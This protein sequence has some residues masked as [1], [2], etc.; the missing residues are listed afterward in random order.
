VSDLSVEQLV[1]L[2]GPK[3]Q[4][5][6]E[7]DLP[8]DE[9]Q[10]ISRLRR[11]LSVSEA[12][13]VLRLRRIR[14]RSS[15]R[16]GP[17]APNLLASEKLAEQ[18]SSWAIA[19]YK[20]ELLAKIA[21]GQVWDLCCGAGVDSIALAQ[22]GL[23]VRGVDRSP[24]ARVCLEHNVARMR[25]SKRVEFL[26]SDVEALSLEPQA[27]VHVDPD[28]RAQRGRTADPRFYAPDLKYLAR[29]VASV[30]AGLI[31]LSPAASGES[32]SALADVSLRWVSEAGVCKQLLAGWGQLAGGPSLAAVIVEESSQGIVFHELPA[33]LAGAAGIRQEGRYVFEPD[34]AVVAAGALNDLAARHDLHLRHPALDLLFGDRQIATPWTRCYR[35]LEE[36]PA[37]IGDV[38]KALSRLGGGVVEV[39]PR[40]VKL[41]TDAFQARLRGSGSRMLSLF[42][43]R[44][45]KPVRALICRRL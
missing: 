41:D 6:L 38:R 33:G 24:E 14:T 37:R 27:V 36:L 21:A 29:L 32:L 19:R 9:L 16:L 44:L 45:G 2:A 43:I 42:W 35:I 4:R 20:A 3:G 5:A 28:R 12:S 1:F 22:A 11:H 10:A 26:A 40:G 17:L 15:G 31:K 34:P 7:A 13:A 23:Q 25:L 30:R 18:A 39:K 8:E